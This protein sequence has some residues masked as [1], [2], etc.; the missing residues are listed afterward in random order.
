MHWDCRHSAYLHIF[1]VLMSNIEKIKLCAVAGSRMQNIQ[2]L[3]YFYC[4]LKIIELQH[5]VK[6]P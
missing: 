2:D 1:D 4:T 6:N 5:A 3:F